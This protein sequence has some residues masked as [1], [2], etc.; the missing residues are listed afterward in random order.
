MKSYRLLTIGLLLMLLVLAACNGNGDEDETP[1]DSQALLT[2]AA[3]N[4][5]AAESFRF[6]VRQSGAPTYFSFEGFEDLEISLN[7][8]NAT[9]E[10]P[11]SVLA[12]ISV[13]IGGQT[14]DIAVIA[15]ENRQYYK[16]PLLTGGEWAQE[17]LVSDF[18][19]SDLLS[20]ESG[21]GNA[22][23]SMRDVTYVGNT[24]VKSVPVYHLRGVVDAELAQ[25]V[26]FG[27]MD[28]ATGDVQMDVYVR[29]EG[30]RRLARIEIVEPSPTDAEED[31]SKTWEIDFDRYNQETNIAEPPIPTAGVAET[32]SPAVAE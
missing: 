26:T 8:A 20:A 6:E 14:Q 17:T 13:L 21:I 3:T 2:E 9:F 16:H 18:E 11:N 22:L 23:L 10:S 24:E 7:S 25:A 28:T 31:L 15:V 12:T 19:P 32:E 1:P 4:I 27:L 5:N 30:T 29:R